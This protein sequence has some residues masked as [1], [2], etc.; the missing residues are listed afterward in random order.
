MRTVTPIWR[1]WIMAVT[2]LVS[3]GIAIAVIVT[4]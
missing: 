4:R 3:V 1:H 2:A